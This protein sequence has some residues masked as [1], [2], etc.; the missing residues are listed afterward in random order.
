MPEN[1]D[2]LIP[3]TGDNVLPRLVGAF[4]INREDECNVVLDCVDSPQ[5]FDF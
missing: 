4:V 5:V 1:D 2:S 3:A